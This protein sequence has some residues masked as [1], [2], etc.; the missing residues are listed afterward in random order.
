MIFPDFHP[1]H[2]YDVCHYN[3]RDDLLS[4]REIKLMP[5]V[6]NDAHYKGIFSFIWP[7]PQSNT[8]VQYKGKLYNECAFRSFFSFNWNFKQESHLFNLSGRGKRGRVKNKAK[9]RS[10]RAGSQFP[11]GRLRRLL[12]KGNCAERIRADAPSI[13]LPSRNTWSLKFWNWQAARDNKKTRIIQDT[14]N[15]KWW[16]IE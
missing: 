16:G 14:C 1:G 5:N 4:T 10:N 9:S 13:W 2:F 11:V 12:L 15:Q 7:H 3:W 6:E 8:K